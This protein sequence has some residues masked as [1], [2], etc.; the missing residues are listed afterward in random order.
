MRILVTGGAGFIGSHV[1]D[2]L[3]AAGHD[4]VVVDNLAAGKRENVNPAAKFY[5]L[6]ICSP[7]LADV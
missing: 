3:I 4:V 7:E 6:D 2:A 1:A 5:R